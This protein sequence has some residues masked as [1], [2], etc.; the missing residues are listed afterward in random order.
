MVEDSLSGH[1]KAAPQGVSRWSSIPAPK[2]RPTKEPP[3]M[4]KVPEM[5][6]GV[7]AD[8]VVDEDVVIS[9]KWKVT[10]RATE[11]NLNKTKK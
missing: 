11:V 3:R 7:G 1:H 2:T 10:E 4:M 6:K 8:R 9:K 5:C